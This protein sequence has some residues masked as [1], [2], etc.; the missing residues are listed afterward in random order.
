MSRRQILGAFGA[1]VRASRTNQGLSQ[2]QLADRANLHRNYI[3]MV[4]RAERAPTL[5]AIEAIARALRMS[6]SEL[7]S[8]AEERIR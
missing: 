4:E 2:E 3:G 1:A 5:L 7:L 6:A 8:R